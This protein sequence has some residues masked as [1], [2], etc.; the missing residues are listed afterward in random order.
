MLYSA[1]INK[2]RIFTGDLETLTRDAWDGDAST[3]A[4]RTSE[5]PILEDSYTVRI[6]STVKTETTDYT[7]DKDTGMLEFVSAPAAGDDNV[8]MDYKYTRLKDDEWLEIIKNV[9]REWRTKI[10]TDAIDSTTH[11]TVAKQ[12]EYDLS[13]ISARII[14]VISVLYRSNS[15]NDWVSVDRDTNIKYIKEQNK[16]QVRPYFDTS[17]YAMKI[18]YLAYYDDDVASTDT[19]AD[20]LADRYFPALQYKCGVEYLD[21]FMAKVMTAGGLKMT[22]ETYESIQ[23]IR[24][25]KKDWES[26]AELALARSRPRMPATNIAVAHYKVRQ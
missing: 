16:L 10:W 23:G 18:R 22:R 7:L 1:L 26:K 8:T 3:K 21:R 19:V 5:R 14:K 6:S 24:Q 12:S 15:N 2:L 17:G 25:L 13:T 9:I 4:F 20:D 11:T